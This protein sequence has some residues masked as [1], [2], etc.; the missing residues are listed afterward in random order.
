MP[1]ILDA[2][3]VLFATHVLPDRYASVTAPQLGALIEHAGMTRGTIYVVCDGSKKPDEW[4]DPASVQVEV[5]YA[6]PKTDADSVI[7]RLIEDSAATKDL[8]VVSNDHRIQRAARRHR[9]VSIGSESFLHKLADALRAKHTGP[10]APEK[11]TGPVDTAAWMEKFGVGE[12]PGKK[13][14]ADVSRE[15][16]R[17]M[18]EFGID[19]K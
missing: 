2:Y 10:P 8:I 17:W 6:G 11:P 15:T 9:A 3:N 18:K 14:P 12:K 7:E 13:P 1:I 5:I 4:L 19:E 16:E